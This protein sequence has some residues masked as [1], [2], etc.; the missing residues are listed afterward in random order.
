MLNA[1]SPGERG[2]DMI[3]ALPAPEKC[4]PNERGKHRRS[5]YRNLGSREVG[6]AWKR[7]SGDEE[8]HR[9]ADA[10]DGA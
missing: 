3:L 8:R 4:G 2:W 1:V 6:G 9:K 10:S 5:E 7:L